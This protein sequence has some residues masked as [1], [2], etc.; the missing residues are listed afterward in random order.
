MPAKMSL[1]PIIL[2]FFPS[3]TFIDQAA[4]VCKC[5]V[6]SLCP[7]ENLQA[8][9]DPQ[10]HNAVTVKRNMDFAEEK[11]KS[12]NLLEMANLYEFGWIEA[13]SVK[14]AWDREIKSSIIRRS[15]HAK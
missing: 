12:S 3:K 9:V 10:K 6:P 8:N 1:R 15:P 4:F 11:E 5:R 2:D 7:S 13:K 14:K